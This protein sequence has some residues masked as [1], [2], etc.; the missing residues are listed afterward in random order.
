MPQNPFP[1]KA[2]IKIVKAKLKILEKDQMTTNIERD[3][4]KIAVSREGLS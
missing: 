1:E 2:K 4:E 3:K